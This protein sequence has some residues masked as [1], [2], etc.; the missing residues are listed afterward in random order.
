LRFEA[1]RS[2]FYFV[3]GVTVVAGPGDQFVQRAYQEAQSKVD[4]AVNDTLTSLFS[5]TTPASPGE[6]LRILRYPNAEA[7]QVA[8]A[9]EIY[10]ITL[11]NVKKYVLDGM[12]LNL[13]DSKGNISFSS[14]Q[15][16]NK[17]CS[18][19]ASNSEII[20]LAF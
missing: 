5:R 13:D 18:H 9:A 12:K 15:L 4:K 10:E 20:G 14:L 17:F 2:D 16:L 3:P 11:A 1:R 7:R 19:C 8:R 6:L